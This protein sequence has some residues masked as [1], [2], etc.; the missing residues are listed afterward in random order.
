MFSRSEGKNLFYVRSLNLFSSLDSSRGPRA[1]AYALKHE[2]IAKI[3]INILYCLASSALTSWTRSI[4]NKR[5]TKQPKGRLY[6]IN[7]P[8]W[9]FFHS[10]TPSLTLFHIEAVYLLR[11][12]FFRNNGRIFEHRQS[13]KEVIQFSAFLRVNFFPALYTRCRYRW[14][15]NATKIE[16]ACDMVNASWGRLKVGSSMLLY[17]DYYWENFKKGN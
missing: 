2:N 9:C 12:L 4:V 7:F 8:N 16:K 14:E 6:V 5:H 13:K 1:I 15:N 11:K 3:I 17:C 10:I